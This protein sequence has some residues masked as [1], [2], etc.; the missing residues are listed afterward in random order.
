M[1][2][3]LSP[4]DLSW[5]DVDPRTHAF[6]P[7]TADEV[8]RSLAPAPDAPSPADPPADWLAARPELMAELGRRRGGDCG[9]RRDPALTISGG[10]VAP[11][12]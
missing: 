8:V 2:R 3:D 11:V 4:R 10:Y 12:S 9:L 5:S 7:A 6:E 1:P